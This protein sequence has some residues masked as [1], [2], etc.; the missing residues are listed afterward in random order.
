MCLKHN[1]R[2]FV[3][4]T[5]DEWVFGTLSP[6]GSPVHAV[7]FVPLT[8]LRSGRHAPR[9]GDHPPPRAHLFKRHV[10]LGQRR[11]PAMLPSP[12]RVRVAAVVALCR[13]GQESHL[14]ATTGGHAGPCQAQRTVRLG[15]GVGWVGDGPG[16]V[17]CDL[18]VS[19]S[20]RVR[21]IVVWC[22]CVC[23][24]VCT[25]ILRVVVR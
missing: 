14:L 17:T 9:K 21:E 15:W 1:C 25:G 13:G 24:C 11:H 12:E 3:L 19:P 23:V 8:S 10:R 6:G 22:V 16:V 4:T 7:Q 20:L 18:P 5:Y 2:Y